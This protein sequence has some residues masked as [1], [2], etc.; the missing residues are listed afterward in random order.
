MM[1]RCIVFIML[2]LLDVSFVRS[3]CVEDAVQQLQSMH[4][5]ASDVVI[6][7][8]GAKPTSEDVFH[9][10]EGKYVSMKPH[11]FVLVCADGKQYKARAEPC[12]QVPVVTSDVARG[13]IIEHVEQ[14]SMP[15]RLI[16]KKVVHSAENLVGMQA[17][18]NLKAN[19][20]VCE[21]QVEK[22]RVVKKGDSITIQYQT[23]F[24][25]ITN[26]GVAQRDGAAGD[27][28]NVVCQKKTLSARVVNANLAQIDRL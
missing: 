4:E 22:P 11:P 6:T 26:Q 13:D 3:D 19:K 15:C 20:P 17:K 8:L 1:M 16:N 21:H 10:I 27:T 14:Q 2:Y 5:G 25:V 28:I 7:W 12:M 24:F 9:A 23:P 18:V